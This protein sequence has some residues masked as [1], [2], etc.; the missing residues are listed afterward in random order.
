[1]REGQALARITGSFGRTFQDVLC[2]SRGYA[3]YLLSALAINREDLLL[4][5]REPE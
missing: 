5:I 3:L 1:V 4:T 2:S